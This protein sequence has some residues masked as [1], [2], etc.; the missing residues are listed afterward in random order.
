MTRKST[1]RNP[2]RSYVT[3]FESEGRKWAETVLADELRAAELHAENQAY[4]RDIRIVHT[5]PLN[6]HQNK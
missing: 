1:A 2:A 3:I 6:P 5:L 4:T